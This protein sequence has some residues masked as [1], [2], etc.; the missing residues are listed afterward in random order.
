MTDKKKTKEELEKK[1]EE[2]YNDREIAGKSLHKQTLYTRDV[3]AKFKPEALEAF[4]RHTKSEIEYSLA[5][6]GLA[7]VVSDEEK[8]IIDIGVNNMAATLMTN[9]IDYVCEIRGEVERQAGF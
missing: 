7:S 9:C 6:T 5:L 3:I 1:L 8:I 4:D 2:S